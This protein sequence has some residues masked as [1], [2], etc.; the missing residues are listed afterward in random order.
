MG[1]QAFTENGR[2]CIDYY[3][4]KDGLTVKKKCE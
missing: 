3:A 2:T 4:Y 1:K